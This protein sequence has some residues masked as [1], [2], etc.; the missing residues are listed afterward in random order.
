MQRRLDPAHVQ[1]VSRIGEPARDFSFPGPL[2]ET[3]K[4]W[5]VHGFDED[6][7]LA[8][9]NA[10]KDMM[11]LLHEHVGLSRNDAYSLM[12]VAGDF[13]ITQVVDGRQGAHVRIPRAVFPV[14]AARG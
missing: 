5:I 14:R 4:W 1:M 12:S 3:P 2:L 13:A 10:A 9:R 8:T 11:T 7:N 6:L